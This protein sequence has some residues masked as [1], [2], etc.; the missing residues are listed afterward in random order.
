M[1]KNDEGLIRNKK[2]VH[3]GVRGEEKEKW[4][5]FHEAAAEILEEEISKKP[6]NV[7]IKKVDTISEL[8]GKRKV[9]VPSEGIPRLKKA[10]EE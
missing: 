9:K 2:G 5:P 7:N 8:Y 10:F 3:V 1:V 4:K 6:E